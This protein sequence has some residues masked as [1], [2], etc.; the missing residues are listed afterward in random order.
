MTRR[1]EILSVLKTSADRWVSGEEIST[2]MTVSRTAIWK[3]ITA[4]RGEGYIIRS[5]P[6]K[7]YRLDETPD[8]PT[9]QEIA[10][11]LPTAVMGKRAI[12]HY[13]RLDS[14][15]NRAKEL[16]LEGADEGTVVIA[17]MQTAGRGRRRRSWHSVP[18]KGLYLSLLVR[19]HIPPADIT[20]MFMLSA[21]AL[22][23]SVE[24]VSGL[25]VSIK[26]PNDI[27]IG[28]KK[29]GGILTEVS[30]DM[31]TVDYVIVGCGVNVNHEPGDLPADVRDTATS[32]YMETGR[33]QSR[34]SLARNF[35]ERFDLYYAH[36]AERDFSVLTTRWR[37]F[38]NVVGRRV[39]VDMVMDS[40]EGRVIEIDDKGALIIEDG[41]RTR[42]RI[43]SG[44]LEYIDK[45]NNNR[46][47]T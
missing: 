37:R 42:H 3:H 23:E 28:R 30:A 41:H 20:V 15:N 38:E 45:N 7:G 6:R 12:Y 17:E 2:R 8:R 13:E 39:R 29:V 11:G 31:D 10:D 24:A 47:V 26:W 40:C 16:A 9:A 14:T 1:E 34:V 27:M 4:L 22:A 25:S 19:P 44:D 43:M 21:L 35:L 18:M 46:S 5:S 36:V 33:T 32:L